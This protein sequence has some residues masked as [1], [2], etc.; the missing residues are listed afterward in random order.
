MVA[1]HERL[2]LDTRGDPVEV[3]LPVEEFRQLVAEARAQEDAIVRLFDDGLSLAAIARAFGT[4]RIQVVDV[5]TR[6]GR[7]P[8]RYT[9]E[10]IERQSETLRRVLGRQAA[11]P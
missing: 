2:V 7:D 11:A 3:V 8:W 5:V 4:Q 10:E 1:T 6:H 9:A